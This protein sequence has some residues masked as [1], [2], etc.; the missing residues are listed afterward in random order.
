ME[1]DDFNVIGMDWSMLCEYE[2]LS[3]INGA[4]KAGKILKEF[5]E[6]LTY[7]GVDINELHIIGHS[8]GAHVAGIAG[9]L[10]KN[11]KIGRITGKYTPIYFLHYLALDT[12]LT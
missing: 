1:T 11:G 4:R 9:G 5:V 3:A 10:I 6:W 2:Y 7:N 8:L 12:K